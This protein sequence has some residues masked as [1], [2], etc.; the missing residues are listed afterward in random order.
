MSRLE[1]EARRMVATPGQAG[2]FNDLASDKGA[3]AV[4]ARFEQPERPKSPAGFAL[5]RA[6]EL[7]PRPHDWL[8]SGLFET[9][10]LVQFFGPPGGAKTFT[11]LD[12]AGCISSGFDYHGRRVKQGPVVYIAGEGFNGIARRRLAWRIF[13][14]IT[15]DDAPLYVSTMPAALLDS[16]N[17]AVVLA[18]IKA[19]GCRP[20]LVI[21]D[22][23]ARNFGPGDENSTADM[24]QFVHAC[25]QI[26]TAFGCTVALVHHTGHGDQHRGR[27]SSVLAGAID[28]AYR[29][30][31]E[32]AGPVLIECAKQKEA[33]PPEPFAFK[34]ESVELGFS[35]KDG[36][37]ATSAI[38]AP[39]D[40]PTQASKPRGKHQTHAVK[41]LQQLIDQQAAKLKRE[42]MDPAT[43]RV[44]RDDWRR[45]CL[46][47]GMI[48][49]RFDEAEKALTERS[50]IRRES[51]WVHLARS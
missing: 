38:L 29:I 33:P 37:P 28:S 23:L 41:I 39:C 4:R 43:A 18:A 20:V 6:G 45:T 32:P 12:M 14:R 26:R 50:I 11:V 8:I 17:L 10:S 44:K 51:P 13:H 42:G 27:G 21:L 19:T 46:N 49:P 5:V 25:D 3:G 30:T 15:V 22:T 40:V 48:A 1:S 16:G 24:G 47:A 2:D 35:N 7:K 36:Q 31:R 34:F 9:D